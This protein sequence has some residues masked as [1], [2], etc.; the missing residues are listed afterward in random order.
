M[1][2]LVGA[3]AFERIMLDRS[4]E[5]YTPINASIE[6]LPLCNMNCD[7]CYVRL[8]REEME[9]QGRL[10]TAQEWLAIGRQMKKAGVLFLLL[11]GG[12]PL[13][14]PEFK[15]VY[16]GLREMGMFLTINTNGTLI[17]EEWAAFF[18]EYKPRR[19]NIT[20]YG[21][22]ENAYRTLCHYPG[23]FERVMR[24]VKLLRQ[25]GVEV[26]LAGSATKQ[27]AAELE[28]LIEIGRELGVPMHIDSY[29][30]PATR[31]RTLPFAQQSRLSPE[32][33]ARA[34]L[35]ALRGLKGDAGFDRAVRE[36]LR[37]AARRRPGEYRTGTSCLAGRC[38]FTVNWQGMMRPC[39]VMTAPQMDVFAQGFDAAWRCI[40]EETG[41]IRTSEEC[42]RCPMRTLCDTCAAAALLE[43]GDYSAKPRYLCR[44]TKEYLR[45]LMEEVKRMQAQRDEAEQ[46]MDEKK[47]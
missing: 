44:Q 12:E 23:G 5:N 3:S 33:A 46:S 17:D 27:N 34:K 18:G 1:D 29:M 14:Y 10:R 41:K 39:V 28:R 4:A 11:T 6:L 16:L 15:A 21:A 45:L 43:E 37:D 8:S 9:R 19:V 7:M 31:E 25:N 30:M 2:L 36:I 22:D 20:L 35:I 26:K 42:H 24:A 32:E 40:C 47:G 13:L 38:S